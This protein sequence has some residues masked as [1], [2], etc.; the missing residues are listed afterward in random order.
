VI[1][2]EYEN[3]PLGRKWNAGLAEALKHDFDY[4]M[5][6][7]SDDLISEELFNLYEWQENAA[8]LSNCYA[9]DLLSGRTALFENNYPIGAGRIIRRDVIEELGDQVLCEYPVGESGP[10]G[11]FGKGRRT[12][13]GK[14]FA[15]AHLIKIEER[16]GKPKLWPDNVN[17]GL[18]YQSDCILTSNRIRQKLI[19]PTRPLIV[20]LKSDVNIWKFSHYPEVDDDAL[21]FIGEKERDAIRRFR[22]ANSN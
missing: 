10:Y 16:K 21:Y 13:F 19:T 3:L 9:Y 1:G 4:L 6:T 14:K 11:S 18:D 15:R 17:Q 2:V 7:G 20:D 22:Q 12:W 5:T 8:G